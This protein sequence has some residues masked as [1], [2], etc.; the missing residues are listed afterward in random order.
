[1]F[2]FLL[3]QIYI[4]GGF[5][6]QEVMCSAEMFDI[7]TSQWSYIPHMSSARSGVSL[8]AFKN[9]LYAIGGF[10]GYTR[11]TTGEKFTPESDTRWTEITEMMTPRSN[12]ATITMDD[13]IY[14]IGGFN[15]KF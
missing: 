13:F 2:S 4:V 7:S 9:A 10:N 3:P 12:F 1:M 14:I 11:L 5:N 15:G 8:V 6:G